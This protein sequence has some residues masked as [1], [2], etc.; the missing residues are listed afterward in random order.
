MDPLSQH[1]LWDLLQKKKSER[2]ILLTTHYMEEAETLADRIAGMK[3][4]QLQC[5]GSSLFL[6]RRFGMGCTQKRDLKGAIFTI[7]I[8]ILMVI[9]TLCV[10]VVK[11]NPAGPPMTLS[12][13]IFQTHPNSEVGDIQVIIADN[14]NVT[15]DTSAGFADMNSYFYRVFPDTKTYASLKH[16]NSSM[17]STSLQRNPAVVLAF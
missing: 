1:S 11:I 9:L 3:Y 14:T 15:D 10:L 5:A 7:L 17:L 13:D 6:K 4:G 2:V 12:P 8:P 16:V